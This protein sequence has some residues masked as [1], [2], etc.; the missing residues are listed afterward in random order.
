MRMMLEKTFKR[1]C[2][3]SQLNSLYAL[4]VACD[5]KNKITYQTGKHFL[6]V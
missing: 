5:M 1:K 6:N 4:M 3:I 2:N